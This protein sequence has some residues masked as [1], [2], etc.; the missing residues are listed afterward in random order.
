M[1]VNPHQA[2]FS[3]QPVL[4]LLRVR[5]EDKQLLGVSLRSSRGFCEAPAAFKT[6]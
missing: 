1:R 4:L 2:C 3:L 5:A 6:V